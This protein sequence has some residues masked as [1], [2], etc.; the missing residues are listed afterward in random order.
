[1]EHGSFYF[2]SYYL[3]SEGECDFELPTKGEINFFCPHCHAEL[4]PAA[5]CGDCGAPMLPILA[6]DGGMTLV[7]SFSGCKSRESIG[8]RR[9]L[10]QSEPTTVGV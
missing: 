7:C 8:I 9:D 3:A 1:M 2:A 10:E 5:N 6:R 4:L